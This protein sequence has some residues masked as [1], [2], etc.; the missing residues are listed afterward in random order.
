[1][2]SHISITHIISFSN[3]N[4][5]L[6]IFLYSNLYDRTDLQYPRAYEG[7]LQVIVTSVDPISRS[8]KR[9]RISR[10]KTRLFSTNKILTF[11]FAHLLQKRA[12]ILTPSISFC[13]RFFLG[14]FGY[15]Q[16]SVALNSSSFL[17]FVHFIVL[18]CFTVL[19]STKVK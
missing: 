7:A 13:H 11:F 6:K 2:E 14:N 1:M 17:H 12:K 5:R 19:L 18:I 3:H 9:P 10:V 15:S 4:Q 8:N 16:I